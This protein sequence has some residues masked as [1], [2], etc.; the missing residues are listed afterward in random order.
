MGIKVS[1]KSIMME[2]LYVEISTAEI[3]SLIHASGGHNPDKFI[4]KSI[5][6]S[7]DPIKTVSQI[8]RRVKLELISIILDDL[9]HRLKIIHFRLCMSS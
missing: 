5:S 6:S 3:S 1:G 7:V 2:L 8:F 9:L 4:E